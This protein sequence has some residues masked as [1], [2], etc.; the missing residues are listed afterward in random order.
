M[1]Q[2]QRTPTVLCLTPTAETAH[3][4][5]QLHVAPLNAYRSKGFE[6]VI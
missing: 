4:V 2:Y 5:G 1:Q 6:Y 3:P